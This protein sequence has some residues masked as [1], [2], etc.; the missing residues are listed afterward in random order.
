M[1]KKIAWGS[2]SKKQRL[3]SGMPDSRHWNALSSERQSKI[4]GRAEKMT[5]VKRRPLTKR[6]QTVSNE[7][8]KIADDSRARA[9]KRKTEKRGL[10]N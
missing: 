6:E 5:D 9:A 10:L 1:S 2:L 8:D 7:L 3:N 4:A